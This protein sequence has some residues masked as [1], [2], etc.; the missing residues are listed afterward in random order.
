MVNEILS[1]VGMKFAKGR[2]INKPAENY[3]VYFD[4]VEVT[5]PDRVTSPFQEKVPR[6]YKH[7]VTVEVYEPTPDDE[8][9]L[10]IESEL[11]AR[12][13]P[14]TKQDRYWLPDTQRYQVIYEFTYHDKRRT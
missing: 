5:G 11:N 3:A 7:D 2:F 8:I 12:G 10:A 4:D 6:I 13:I 9:E 14:W 1:A